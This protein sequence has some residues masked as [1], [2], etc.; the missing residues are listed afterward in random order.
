MQ[1]TTHPPSFTSAKDLQNRM[2][3]LPAGPQWKSTEIKLDGYKTESPLTLY[4]RDG[5]QVIEHLFSNPIFA[6]S[7]EMTP[8]H[9][10]EEGDG[11]IYQEFMS[12]DEAWRLQVCTLFT[13]HFNS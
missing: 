3:A 4:W 2:E 13:S 7:M 11:R 9:T 10:Y 5:L 1:V 12:A 8:Y 6:Q